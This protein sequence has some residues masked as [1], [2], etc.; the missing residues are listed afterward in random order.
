MM[1]NILMTDSYKTSHYRQYPQGTQF[2]SSYIESRGIDKN[3]SFYRENEDPVMLFFGLQKFIRDL[4]L[5]PIKFKDIVDAEKLLT[6]HGVPFNRGGWEYI[7]R[8]YNGRLPLKI[9]SIP[10]GTVLPLSLPLVSVINTDPKVPWLTSYIETALLRAVWYPSTVATNSWRIKQDIKKFLELSADNTEGLPFKLH[11]FGARGVSSAESA[12]IGGMA[13]L[14]NFMGTD[15]IEALVGANYY[16]NEPVAGFSIPAA[17]HSTITAWGKD[18]E[19]QAFRNMLTQFGGI[20]KILAVVSD[21]YDIYNAVDNLWGGVLRDEVIN[22]G[23][24]VVVRPDSGDPATVVLEVVE[25]LM[26]KFGYERNS[27]GYK[28]LPDY[29]RVIQ[30]DGV[31]RE[32]INEILIALTGAYISADNVAFGM[33]GA[34]LQEVNRDSFKFAMKASAAMVKN[35]WRDVYKTTVTDPGKASKR[36]LVDT[37]LN[38]DDGYVFTARKSPELVGTGNS[39]MRPVFYNGNIWNEETFAQIRARSEND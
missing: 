27:K 26:D 17:E 12:Q 35:E 31:N 20:G 33:G 32:S 13:H 30:G 16:Y 38:P 22:N 7:H 19:V 23:A 39:I 11:D 14:V 29:L 34:L 3:V 18:N 9:F 5:N 25:R 36:G 8:E 15:T 2:V 10:E 21:S 37:V 24:T 1:N 6:A 4:S 28:V